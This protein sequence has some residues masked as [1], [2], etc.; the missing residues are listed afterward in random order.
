MTRILIICLFAPIFNTI[1]AQIPVS[2][3]QLD[4]HWISSESS[5]AVESNW[6][7]DNDFLASNQIY[8]VVQGDTVMLVRSTIQS[9]SDGATLMN[10]QEHGQLCMQFKLSLA[11]AF[12]STWTNIDPN[13]I[14]TCIKIYFYKKNCYRITGLTQEYAFKHAKEGRLKV[15]TYLGGGINTVSS[16]KGTHSILGT[17]PLLSHIG[18]EYNIGVQLRNSNSPLGFRIEFGRGLSQYDRLSFLN[19]STNL[20]TYHQD[21]MHVGIFPEGS[22]GKRQQWTVSV[23]LLSTK[24]YKMKRA[25]IVSKETPLNWESMEQTKLLM[26]PSFGLS[27]AFN[28]KNTLFKPQLYVRFDELR[29]AS[30]GVR[31][32]F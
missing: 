19:G 20:V 9:T 32:G 21:Y 18:W 29:K 17:D 2:L 7:F 1:I 30:L 8:Q 27:Y 4:G 31:M 15:N 6:K 28:S 16:A 25:V 14:P 23:G 12:E 26:R 24:G 3:D 13:A 11:T 10:V 5:S 22:F